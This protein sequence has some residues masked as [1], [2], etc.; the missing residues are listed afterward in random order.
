L[1]RDG[2]KLAAGERRLELVGRLLGVAPVR[3]DLQ[4][5]LID[6]ERLFAFL[7]RF[8][9]IPMPMSAPRCLGSRLSV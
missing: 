2:L 3:R 9:I 4:D 8:G 7:A 5:A 6:L 1:R